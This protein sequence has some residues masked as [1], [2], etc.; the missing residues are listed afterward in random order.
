MSPSINHDAETF[1]PATAPKPKSRNPTANIDSVVNIQPPQQRATSRPKPKYASRPQELESTVNRT[2]TKPNSALSKQNPKKNVKPAAPTPKYQP[3]VKKSLKGFITACDKMMKDK[4]YKEIKGQTEEALKN[5]VYGEIPQDARL[6]LFCGIA[7]LK[8]G[9][10][11]L[12]EQMLG[13]CLVFPEIE[14]QAQR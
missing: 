4:K 13:N 8:L 9:Y 7:N 2:F 11:I 3:L 14:A 10:L 1:K 12:A 5:K 6:F